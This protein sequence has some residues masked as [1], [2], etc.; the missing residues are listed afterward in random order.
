[1]CEQ[2]FKKNCK[3]HWSNLIH[4]IIQEPEIFCH[5][6]PTKQEESLFYILVKIQTDKT[7]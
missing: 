2:A 7:S 5:R 4:H 6:D 1:M 3:S